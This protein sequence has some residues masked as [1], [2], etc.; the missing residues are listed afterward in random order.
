META[1]HSPAP[2][3]IPFETLQQLR[4]YRFWENQV[5]GT[6]RGDL[7]IDQGANRGQSEQKANIHL[8][9]TAPKLLSA[10][11]EIMNYFSKLSKVHTNSEMTKIG[12]NLAHV[13]DEAKNTN[14]SVSIIEGESK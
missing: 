12:W 10:C 8:M 1:K 7:K 14:T 11:E 6:P 13:I 2:W 9:A 3:N 4:G 5:I